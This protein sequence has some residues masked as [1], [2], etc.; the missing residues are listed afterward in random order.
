[1]Q[2]HKSHCWDIDSIGLGKL[3]YTEKKT[4]T[5]VFSKLD[6]ER[7]HLIMKNKGETFLDKLNGMDLV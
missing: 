2:K 3:G 5:Q 7:K 4:L 6:N 1:M